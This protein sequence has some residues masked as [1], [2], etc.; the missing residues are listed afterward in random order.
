MRDVY[1]FIYLQL[2]SRRR[3]SAASDVTGRKFDGACV[4]WLDRTRPDAGASS[5]RESIATSRF[6]SNHI[7]SHIS[8]RRQARCRPGRVCGGVRLVRTW[9]ALELDCVRR[10]LPYTHIHTHRQQQPLITTAHS[11]CRP[12]TSLA[13]FSLSLSLSLCVCVCVCVIQFS[14]P[15]LMSMRLTSRAA[16]ELWRI[17]VDL[18]AMTRWWRPVCIACKLICFFHLVFWFGVGRRASLY[19]DGRRAARLSKRTAVHCNVLLVGRPAHCSPLLARYL[20]TLIRYALFVQWQIESDLRPGRER[21]SRRAGVKLMC[22]YRGR[23]ER[24]AAATDAVR[25]YSDVD[26]YKL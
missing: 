1:L 25:N 4:Q 24:A 17:L 6:T 5:S 13:Q 14:C 19:S 7:H 15:P 8:A 9:V 21:L 26:V 3:M 12:I 11:R 18:L 2:Y 23:D 22:L 20:S 10:W 16:S